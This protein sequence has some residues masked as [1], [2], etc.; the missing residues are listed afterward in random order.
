MAKPQQP[1]I[2]TADMTRYQ[3]GR[4]GSRF[5]DQTIKAMNAHLKGTGWKRKSQW[6]FKVEGDWY[7]TA[8]SSGVLAPDG[9]SNMMRV[10]FGIKPMAVDPINWR[11]KGLHD[12]LK[13]PPSFRSNAAFKVP[14]LPMSER[15]WTEGLIDPTAAGAMV[16]DAIL[17]MA[18]HARAQVAGR[19]FSDVV[20]AHK[21][22]KR[23]TALYVAALIAE[24][25]GEA[26]IAALK[27]HYLDDGVDM[28][29]T[30][31]LADLVAGYQHVIDGSDQRENRSLAADL[32]GN[33]ANGGPEL[34]LR[35]K[36]N[37]PRESMIRRFIDRLATLNSPPDAK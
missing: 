26:A 1:I 35:G 5:L 9:M 23:W 27:D 11:A 7:L 30:G 6:V 18:D 14:A 3:R 37:T 20:A 19:K 33:L 21:D 16:F 17:D 8:F 32:N 31:P 22:F 25:E 10:Q 34:D 24:G 36:V 28:P 12:N 29:T 2:P 13:K 15:K 4:C